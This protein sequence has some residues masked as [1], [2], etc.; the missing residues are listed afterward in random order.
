MTPFEKAA[1]VYRNE[2]C[3][4]SFKED[5]ALHFQHGWVISAPR[6]FVM[7]RPVMSWWSAENIL[8]P[9][10][11]PVPY[12]GHDIIRECHVNCW[13]VWLA[14]G[15]LKEALKFLPFPLPYISFERKNVLKMYSFDKF[16]SKL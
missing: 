13:H 11:S 5:L 12:P 2:W 8:N 1:D 16:V 4:R 14:A 3:A 10:Y 7:G 6:F 9:K 15:D